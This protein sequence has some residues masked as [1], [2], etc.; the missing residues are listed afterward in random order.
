MEAVALDVTDIMGFLGDRQ[1][2]PKAQT[3]LDGFPLGLHEFIPVTQVGW[4]EQDPSQTPAHQFGIQ[5]ASIRQK[6]IGQ[7]TVILIIALQI[8]FQTQFRPLDQLGI[9]L[10]GLLRRFQL[11]RI[12]A[13]QFRCIYTYIA[14]LLA[15]GQNDGV[16][17]QYLGREPY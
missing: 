10:F 12:S 17:V 1:F 5:H 14:Y 16:P 6:D 4:F 9:E 8:V 13:A 15:V 3:V 7:Q 11:L 2:L